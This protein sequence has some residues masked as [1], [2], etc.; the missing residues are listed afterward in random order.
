VRRVVS[1]GFVVLFLAA[2]SLGFVTTLPEVKASGQILEY[3]S[4][5]YWPIAL[6]FAPDGRIFFA[7]R[8]TGNIRIIQNNA[9]L[10]TPYYTLAN[11]EATDERGLLGLALDPGFPSPP[12]VYAYHTYN[13]TANGTVYNRIVRISGTG[14]AGTFDS[15]ILRLPPLT[16]ATIHNGGV[17]AFGPDRKLYAVVGENADPAH[18][19]DPLSPMGKVLRMNRDGTPPSDNPFVGNVSWNPLVFTFGHRNMFGITF[20][21]VTGRVYV[22]EN[23]PACNDEINLLVAGRNYGWGPRGYA[24]TCPVPPARDINVTNQDG[25]SPVLPIFYW[26]S[27]TICPTNA[28]IYGGPFFPALRG[29]LFMGECKYNRLH[30]LRLTPPRYDSVASDTILWTAPSIILDVRG[31][32]DGAIWITTPLAIY[33]YWD[34]SKAPIAQFTINPVPV[35]PGV[36]VTF[37]AT[38]SYATNAT[39][40]SYAWNFGDSSMGTGATTTHAYSRSGLFSVTLTVTDNQTLS[41][42]AVH[43]VE[44]RN[45]APK[46]LS[47]TPGAGSVNLTAGSSQAFLVQVSD[48]DGDFLTYTWRVNGAVVGGNASSFTFTPTSAGTYTVNVTASDGPFVVGRQWTVTVVDPYLQGSGAWVL[49]ILAAAYAGV[50]FLVWR[51][52]RKRKPEAPPPPPP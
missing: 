14:S 13:D 23:G 10:P 45:L 33:R 30:L 41:S 43:Q 36:P 12:Y 8:F 6:A 20:H 5:L 37:D 15:V 50:V 2:A 25:P 3:M 48:P 52:R 19:Q 42:T 29:S 7:E 39:I 47:S 17:I 1:I 28:A 49:G 9:L 40:V 51:M 34:S 46:I 38:S 4:G 27:P 31:G 22:T 21:P 11:T 26:A 32:P 44:V 16:T 35:D 24:A 18:S